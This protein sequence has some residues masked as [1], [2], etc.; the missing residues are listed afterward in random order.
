LAPSLPLF[1]SGSVLGPDKSG[2]QVFS[3]DAV[4]RR[5][6][7]RA[8]LDRETQF[9]IEESVRIASDVAGAGGFVTFEDRWGDAARREGL[10]LPEG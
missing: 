5:R 9:G 6:D 8:Q 4:H 3:C 2:P 10:S 7:L 1:D